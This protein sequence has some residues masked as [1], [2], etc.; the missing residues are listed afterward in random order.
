MNSHCIATYF[1]ALKFWQMTHDRGKADPASCRFCSI[2]VVFCRTLLISKLPVAMRI[3][4]IT[5][6]LCF[7]Y[8]PVDCCLLL[9]PVTLLCGIGWS[10][11]NISLLSEEL[12][13]WEYR[14][15]GVLQHH[16]LFGHTVRFSRPS[17]FT[18]FFIQRPLIGNFARYVFG[19]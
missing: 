7:L 17:K 18:I 14:K 13:C 15:E 2:L 5:A 6:I 8:H 10:H 1:L 16:A 12:F 9:H 4:V 3:R 19:F 11:L